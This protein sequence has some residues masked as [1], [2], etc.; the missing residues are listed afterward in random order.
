LQAMM[1][2]IISGSRRMYF[3]AWAW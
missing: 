3:G 1:L 2:T